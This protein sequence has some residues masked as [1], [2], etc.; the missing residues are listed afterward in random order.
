METTNYSIFGLYWSYMGIM[1]KKM[2]ITIVHYS[3]ILLEYLFG[4]VHMDATG[5]VQ[6]KGWR[7][8][9]R[10]LAKT[11]RRRRNALVEL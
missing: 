6:A 3:A 11:A 8:F 4:T 7:D 5:S 10:Q 1:E 9:R 2:E